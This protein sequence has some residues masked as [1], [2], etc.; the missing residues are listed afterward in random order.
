MANA[1][2]TQLYEP[3]WLQCKY[4]D[5]LYTSVDIAQ[6]IGCHPATVRYALQKLGIPR[7]RRPT[8][9]TKRKISES[10]RGK[11]ISLETRRK[12]AESVRA[13]PTR[14]WL[15]KK[16]SEE[17]REKMR[18]RKSP[19]YWLGKSRSQE[20]KDKISA[21]TLGKKLSRETRKKISESVSGSKNWNWQGGISRLPYSPDFDESLK[22]KVRMF[23]G[24]TCQ[25]CREKSIGRRLDVHHINYVKKDSSFDN[26]IAL[27]ASCHSKVDWSREYWQEY[28]EVFVLSRKVREK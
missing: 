23:W 25:L 27:C 20:T 9:A 28:F 15:G 26:L 21:S 16:R 11:I 14:Y 8:E 10:E 2:Y 5:S 4:I 13:N 3:G 17:T 18:G 1:T 7:R 19:K 22:E 24:R 6:D 12:I